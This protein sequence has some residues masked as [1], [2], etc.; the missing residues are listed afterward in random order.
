METGLHCHTFRFV[1]SQIISLLANTGPS[2]HALAYPGDFLIFTTHPMHAPTPQ[3]IIC[4]TETQ[5]GMFR[6]PA[7]L[8][9]ARSIGY[10]PQQ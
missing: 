3:A 5:H 2:L 6:M 8:W 1:Y 7:K 10:G 9:Q 4:S